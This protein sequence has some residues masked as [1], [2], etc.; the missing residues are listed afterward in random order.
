M[1][2]SCALKHERTI[3]LHGQLLPLAELKN[4]PARLKAELD[5]IGTLLP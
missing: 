5:R 3:S 2:P 4:D 1:I